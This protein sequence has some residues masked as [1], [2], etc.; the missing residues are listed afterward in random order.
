MVTLMVSI[1]D[2][3]KDGI[4]LMMVVVYTIQS[5][6]AVTGHKIKIKENLLAIQIVQSLKAGTRHKHN[7]HK[8]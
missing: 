8:M 2:T 3:P 7:K 6:K 4:K 1:Q 5:L